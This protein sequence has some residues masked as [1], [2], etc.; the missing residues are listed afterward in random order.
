M[1]R[2]RE[3]YHLFMAWRYER[4]LAKKLGLFA[5]MCR[6]AMLWRAEDKRERQG[7]NSWQRPGRITSKLP[8]V[9][10]STDTYQSAEKIGRTTKG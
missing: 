9:M 5:I 3:L 2:G 6:M 10:Q 7:R 1:T 8:V 4:A